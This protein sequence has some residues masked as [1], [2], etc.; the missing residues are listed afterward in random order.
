M[1][2]LTKKRAKAFAIDMAI[3]TAVT[4]VVEVL[5]R[6]KVKN[7]F[8]H[9]VVTP[10][11]VTYGLEYVQLKNS[12]QTIGYK[13]QGLKLV[14]EDGAPLEGCALVKRMLYRDYVSSLRYIADRKNFA[15]H[16]SAVLPHDAKTHCYV[17]QKN[18]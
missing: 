9:V 7:E 1:K 5:L 18:D 11:L 16:D 10:T 15:K 4:G 14:S 2:T 17:Q 12:G 8:V 13:Q 6:K 3:A